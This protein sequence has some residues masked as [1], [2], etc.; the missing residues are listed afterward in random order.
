MSIAT[1]VNLTPTAASPTATP[2]PASGLQCVVFANDGGTPTVNC[3][4]TDPVMVGDTG[5]G[6]LAGNAPAPPSGS[7]AAGK[8]LKADGTWAVPPGSS[9]SGQT[10][11]GGST[12]G[13]AVF[14]EPFEGTDYKKVIVLLQA[15]DGTAS[16]TFPTAFTETPD[17]FIGASASGAT[18]TALS[19]TAVTISG[20]PSSGVIVLEGY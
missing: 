13:T 6:G 4:A 5:S 11:V 7:A 12:S 2:P 9:G 19:T 20:A 8:F 15:L 17:Y 3:S 14:S 1:A 18:V 16:Y 10:S